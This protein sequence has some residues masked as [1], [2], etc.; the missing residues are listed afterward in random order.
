MLDLRCRE[1]IAPNRPYWRAP[2]GA[3]RRQHRR[4]LAGV[5]WRDPELSVASPAGT[6][7][8]SAF[9]PGQGAGRYQLH[10]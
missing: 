7:N 5:T 9:A 3:R 8:S 4:D 6:L 2:P 10:D 1:A